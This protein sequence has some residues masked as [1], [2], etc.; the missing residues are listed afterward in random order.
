MLLC[1]KEFMTNGKRIQKYPLQGIN[2]QPVIAKA[3]QAIDG[4]AHFGRP[5]EQP[6]QGAL[7]QLEG[8]QLVTLQQDALSADN[9]L[10][11]H[12]EILPAQEGD[13]AFKRTVII[14]G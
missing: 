13:P 10:A 2:V 1:S 8:R 12:L 11:H 3:I 9:I 14:K 6:R 7:L 5:I 4:E